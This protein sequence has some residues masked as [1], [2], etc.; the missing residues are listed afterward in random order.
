MRALAARKKSVPAFRMYDHVSGAKTQGGGRCTKL[1]D[2]EVGGEMVSWSRKRRELAGE[3]HQ[4]YLVQA[5]RSV[6]EHR[7]CSQLGA[8]NDRYNRFYVPNP[9]M[10]TCIYYSNGSS[11]INPL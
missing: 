4:P 3:R 2:G 10:E 9:E 11:V 6:L 8:Y 5:A 1:S 7:P